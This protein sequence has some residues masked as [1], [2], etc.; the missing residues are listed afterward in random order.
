MI[1][2]FAGAARGA[3]EQKVFLRLRV[4]GVEKR[5]ILVILRDGDGLCLTQDLEAAGVRDIAGK[6]ASRDGMDLVSLAS[7][8]PEITFRLDEKAAALIIDVE[9]DHLSLTRL[10]LSQSLR[11]PDLIFSTTPGLF[12]NYAVETHDRIRPSAY[13]EAGAS[14]ENALLYTGAS[15]SNGGEVVRGLSN[16]TFDMPSSLRRIVMG[17]IFGSSSSALGS[18][19]LLGGLSIAREFSLDP[20]FIS[21]PHLEVRGTTTTPSRVQ[22]YRNGRLDREETI[23]PGPFELANLPVFGTSGDTRIVVQDAFGRTQQFAAGY[24][25]SAN[26]LAPGLSDYAYQIGFR[27]N[28]FS[29]TSFSY[30]A[31]AVFARH[32][33][34]LADWLTGALRFEADRTL[35]S[36]GP[37][38]TVSTPVGA[39]EMSGAASR[40]GRQS[41]A[42]ASLSIGFNSRYFGLNGQLVA[43]SRAFANLN[44]AP[45]NDRALLSLR[46]YTSTSLGPVSIS[47]G[48]SLSQMRDTS[49]SR[50]LLAS[51]N[52]RLLSRLNLGLN[53]AATYGEGQV[54]YSGFVNL[55]IFLD[56]FTSASVATQSDASRTQV[57]TQLQKS[58]PVGTGFGYLLRG[59]GDDRGFPSA[60]GSAELQYQG[61]GGRYEGTYGRTATTNSWRVSAAGAIVVADGD[62]FATRPVQDGFGVI[63]V[64][65]VGGVRGYLNNQEVGRTNSSGRLIVPSVTPY[66]GNHFRIADHDVPLNYRIDD[67]ERTVAGPMRGGALARFRVARVQAFSGVVEI[68]SGLASVVAANGELNLVVEGKRQ[69]FPVGL[70]GQFYLE[71][72]APGRYEAEVAYAGRKCRFTLALPDSVKT[73]EDLGRVG[74]AQV[75][76]QAGA[77]LSGRLFID[78]NGNGQRDEDEPLL[79]EVSLAVGDKHV[80]TDADGRFEVADLPSGTVLVAPVGPAELPAGYYLD[81]RAASI[82]LPEGGEFAHDL[83]VI[84]PRRLRDL[85]SHL[86]LDLPDGPLRLDQIQAATFPL[87]TWTQGQEL[88][89]T[90]DA[91][92]Q[93]LGTDVLD[94]AELRVLV[95]VQVPPGEP[96]PAVRQA[97]RGARAVLRY[98]KGPALVPA[99]RLIWTLTSPEVGDTDAGHVDVLLVRLPVSRGGV[100]VPEDAR[101]ARE[102]P[103]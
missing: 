57:S 2:E 100:V 73:V 80:R 16:L 35:A 10:D 61:E 31:P 49:G 63:D 27:R 74:C 78:L 79:D 64:P 60:A 34:G 46:F 50:Q 87:A 84:A 45:Q 98:L 33:I 17:D 9:P 3:T 103:W 53:G 6:R 30:G 76:V 12:V 48:H 29:H 55:T 15:R 72:V 102:D 54:G 51:L 42:A 94:A 18:S 8:A 41:G 28:D 13:L 14:V 97:L 99:S 83:P 24:L 7:L 81:P 38:L 95:V 89:Q 5:D 65:G 88:T 4:N 75:P 67:L 36:G 39:F 93:R 92:L 40:S 91:T 77:A 69:Q 21:A 59:Q 86:V 20:Y 70:Q 32:R 25:T 68:G 58:L 37:A 85:G 56:G 1:A 66:Y 96:A 26:L 19:V 71:N 47:L 44:L 52:A 82:V 23:A 11:P 22:V 101:E 43:M 62:L 90:E